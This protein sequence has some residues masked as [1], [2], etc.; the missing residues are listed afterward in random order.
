MEKHC[1]VF[2]HVKRDVIT[3]KTSHF[4]FK[5]Y[6]FK[7]IILYFVIIYIYIFKSMFFFLKYLPESSV[8]ICDTNL[9]FKMTKSCQV[10]WTSIS[11]SV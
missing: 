11:L 3:E 5:H 7:Y 4:N 10:K 8:V 6:L 1:A 9:V 2:E